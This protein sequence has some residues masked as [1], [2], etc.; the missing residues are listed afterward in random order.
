VNE[1]LENEGFR[2][3]KG[4]RVNLSMMYRMFKE[5]FYYGEFEYPE[6]SGNCYKGA[7]EPLIT[8]EQWQQ[9]NEMLKTYEKSKWGSKTFYYS[10]LF[11]CGSCRSGVCG[12][13]HTNRH[14]TQYTYYKCTKYGGQKRCN[15]KYI[16][17]EKL[18]E[19]IAKMIEEN[20]EKDTLVSKKIERE[21]QKINEIQKFTVG[22]NAK[23]VTN[24]G[25]IQY[26]LNGGTNFERRQFLKC[27]EGQLYLKEGEVSLEKCE[28]NQKIDPNEADDTEFIA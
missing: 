11:K 22:L 21:V 9:A 24:T 5:T 23:E 20:K 8:K 19:S 27:I 18:I 15:E 17:E 10:K 1:F 2:T 6:G 16:R 7:H 13:E 3:R 12:V 14:G 25:Y 4:K 28:T 26:I